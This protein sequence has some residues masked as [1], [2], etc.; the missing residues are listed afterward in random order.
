MSSVRSRS[1][2]TRIGNTLRRNKQVGAELPLTH[3]LLQVPVG[4]RDHARVRAQRLVAADA[5]ELALLEHAQECD[6]DGR[7]QLAHLV[8]ED[9]ASGRQLEPSFPPLQRARERAPLVAE[10]LGRDRALRGARRS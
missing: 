10:Q 4:G 6:L 3:R 8:E 1:G 7:R 2:G 5:L 9:R